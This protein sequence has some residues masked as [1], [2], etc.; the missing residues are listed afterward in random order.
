MKTIYFATDHAG[1]SLKNALVA[2]VREEL[3]YEVVDCGAT[4]LDA[5]DDYPDFIQKA[6]EAVAEAPHD[7]MAI[8]LGGSG[9]GEAIVANRFPGVRAA[10]YYGGNSEIITLSRLHNDANVLSL[11]ARFLT[12]DEAKEVVMEWLNTEFS[13]EDRHVRRISKI[14]ET[15]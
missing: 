10:V 14:D 5:E 15:K 4:S 7:R 2:Y 6:A 1:F 8:I 13:H 12:E 11:G 3:S 9:T